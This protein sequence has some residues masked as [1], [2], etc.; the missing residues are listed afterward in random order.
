[1]LEG[2]IEVPLAAFWSEAVA[3]GRESVCL[4]IVDSGQ[5]AV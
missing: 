4:F 3:V 2:L 1:M 5:G